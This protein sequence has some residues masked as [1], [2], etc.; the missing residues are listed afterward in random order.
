MGYKIE[1]IAVIMA[2]VALSG[3]FNFD[4][5]RTKREERLHSAFMD[6]TIKEKS[7]AKNIPRSLWLI[8]NHG[9]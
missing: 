9:V 8:R 7:L 4:S 1:Y 2:A 5:E 3:C 6:W